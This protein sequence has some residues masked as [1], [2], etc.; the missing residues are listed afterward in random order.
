[1]IN[2]NNL[3]LKTATT[4]G[5]T[6][7]IF[8]HAQTASLSV[9]NALIDVTTKSS[10]SWKEMISGQK[11]WSV[12]SDGLVDYATVADAQNFTALADLAIAGTKVF[13]EIGVGTTA[14]D[15]YEGEA[16]IASIEQTGGTDD[17]AT[18]SISLEGTGALTAST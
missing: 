3:V 4:S 16:F 15:Q 17:A 5:G 11:S 1:M 14:G 13:I 9:N 12:S 10:N 18:Y 6:K 8:A 2:G 7:T